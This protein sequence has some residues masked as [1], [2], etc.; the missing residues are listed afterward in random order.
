M[1]DFE[2]WPAER[3]WHFLAGLC[4]RYQE[5]LQDERGR[6]VRYGGVGLLESGATGEP[7]TITTTREGWIL[8][9]RD[10]NVKLAPRSEDHTT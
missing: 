8:H 7:G 2:T 5:P 3:V 1:I 6:P 9:C 4:R 10:G